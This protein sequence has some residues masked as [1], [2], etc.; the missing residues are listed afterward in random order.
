MEYFNSLSL[1]LRYELGEDILTEVERYRTLVEAVLDNKD[2]EKLGDYIQSFRA[3]SSYFAFL[4][5]EYDYYTALEDFIEGLYLA[6]QT[7]NARALA[8]KIAGVY[9]NRLRII[10]EFEKERQLELNDRIMEEINGF[11]RVLLY[12]NLY[13]SDAVRDSMENR[14]YNSI[15]DLAVF[16]ELIEN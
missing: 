7:E 12:V 3:H 10:G 16:G 6:K 5:G 15:K 1:D 8:D 4:Y 13:D 14:V 2:I 11:R 9:E